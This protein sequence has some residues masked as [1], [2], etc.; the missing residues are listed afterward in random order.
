MPPSSG[1]ARKGA[2]R[3]AEIKADKNLN[4]RIDEATLKK[5]AQLEKRWKCTKS[6]AV[7]KA[8]HDA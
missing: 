6:E 8:I 2:G 7:R 1:G 4:I 3:K 5:L